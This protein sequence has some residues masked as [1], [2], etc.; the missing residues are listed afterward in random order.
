[1]TVG[2]SVIL[3]SS[4]PVKRV[5]LGTPEGIT[6]IAVAM[7]L[8]PRQIYLT[9]KNPGVTNLT[10]WG[11]TGKISA[12][13]DLEVSPDISRLKEMIQKIMPEEKHPG[14]CDPRQHNFPAPFRAC[15]I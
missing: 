8:T 3:A 5:S 9:G 10:I 4:E 2:K 13:M 7:V 11:T 1:L 15:P 12:V 14:Y 6:E